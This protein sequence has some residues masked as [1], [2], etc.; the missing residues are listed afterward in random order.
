VRDREAVGDV[1]KGAGAVVHLA[2]SLMGAGR[3]TRAINVEGSR[4]VFRAGRR[5]EGRA[6]LLRVEHRRV[7]LPRRQSHVDHRGRT[8]TGTPEQFCSEQKAE[9]EGVLDD[10]LARKRRTVA[11]VLRPCIVAGPPQMPPEGMLPYIRLSERMPDAFVRLLSGMPVLRPVLPD[12]GLRFQLVHE[13]DVAAA[14]AAAVTGR[15]SP[16]AYN[17]AGNG[18]ITASDL[19]RARLVLGP[20]PRAHGRCGR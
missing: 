5:A 6:H 18:T 7:R 13:D 19:A 9:V 14:F 8:G 16:G 20:G 1:L 2:F 10:V 11:Y 17:L 12:T 3:N 15:G 4:N